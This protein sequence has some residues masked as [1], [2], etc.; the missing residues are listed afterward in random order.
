MP[1]R[2]SELTALFDRFAKDLSSVDGVTADLVRC[3]LCIRTFDR[4]AILD[5][6]ADGL[7][8]EHIIPSA[9]GGKEITLTCRS[10]NNRTASDIEAHF[11]RMVRAVD[12]SSGDGSTLEGRFRIG[13]EELPLKVAWT[14]GAGP[15]VFTIP[16]GKPKVLEQYRQMLQKFG[17]GDTF[18]FT[19]KL[20]YKENRAKQA[21]VRIAYLTLFH[22]FGYKYILTSAGEAI[23]SIILKGSDEQVKPFVIRIGNVQ[24]KNRQP[25]L[26]ILEIHLEGGIPAYLVVLR[27]HTA[28]TGFHGILMPGPDLL[29]EL[30]PIPK[31]EG[32]AKK[33]DG[34]QFSF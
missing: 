6:G 27:L 33:L 29:K 11:V 22:T 1:S 23:R 7:S 12:W 4:D 2:K 28:R 15:V 9:L 24:E 3:P 19:V 14:D 18:N 5:L 26:R 8:I 17:E 31:L 13:D 34:S 32:V 20:D 30:D 21:M 25:P 10:C 16:G